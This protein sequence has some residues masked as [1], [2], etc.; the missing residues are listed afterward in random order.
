MLMLL[1]VLTTNN[2]FGGINNSFCMKIEFLKMIY[3]Y[4]RSYE[5]CNFI[6]GTQEPVGNNILACNLRNIESL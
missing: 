1:H 3:A 2:M 6:G 5:R 4:F